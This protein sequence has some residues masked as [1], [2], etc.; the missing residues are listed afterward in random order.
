ML[1]AA[2]CWAG[3]GALLYYV[4][5]DDPLARAGFF[6]L[7]FGAIFFALAPPLRGLSRRLAR[8][9]LYQEAAGIHATRQALMLAAFVVLNALMQLV[10]AWSGL[11]AV[12]LLGVFVIIEIVA[13]SRR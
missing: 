10:R 11:N 8:S 3:L 7:L 5:P 13:L 1:L 2:L 4:S 12:L 9:R 6:L